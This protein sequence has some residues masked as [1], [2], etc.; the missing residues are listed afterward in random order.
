M[1]CVV[2][3]QC[4]SERVIA[5]FRQG[6]IIKVDDLS[7]E[8]RAKFADEE[9]LFVISHDCD[10]TAEVSKEPFIEVLTLKIL[11]ENEQTDSSLTYGRSPRDID[12]PVLIKGDRKYLKLSQPTKAK[13][14]KEKNTNIK[15]DS[16]CMLDAKG[17]MLLR[18]W[19]SSRYK[20]HSF[21]ESLA[22][23]LEKLQ[24]KLEKLGKSKTKA[25]GIIA[26][27]INVDPS[28]E[29]LGETEP[30]EID[31]VIVYE[32]DIPHASTNANNFKKDITQ[33]LGQMEAGSIIGTVKTRSDAEFTF[34][35]MRSYVEWRF[36]H[37]SFRGDSVGSITPV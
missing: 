26:L 29:E 23:R 4:E 5:K 11:D 27:F 22:Y 20:R 12:L 2:G 33:C 8:D 24:K 14:C 6:S 34:K 15:A 30:Y 7:D 36:E 25:E 10:I 35:D 28:E 37:L 32:T 18:S 3:S 31:I 9:Y 19:L 13:I 16:D 21:P 1:T 17:M